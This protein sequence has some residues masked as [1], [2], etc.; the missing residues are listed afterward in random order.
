MKYQR[1]KTD[2]FRVIPVIPLEL[3]A[4][5]KSEYKQTIN[6]FTRMNQSGSGGKK[7]MVKGKEAYRDAP[8][9]SYKLHWKD[10]KIHQYATLP[11]SDTLRPQLQR[12]IHED[13]Q[14][15]KLIQEKLD[16]S[17]D[18]LHAFAVTG[19]PQ[20]YALDLDGE[21]QAKI[22]R[23]IRS[24]GKSQLLYS[25]T[26]KEVEDHDKKRQE[27][28]QRLDG[29]NPDNK[30]SVGINETKRMAA[31]VGKSFYDFWYRESPEVKE[32]HQNI[33]QAFGSVLPDKKRKFPMTKRKLA[34]T[35]RYMQVEIL[36]LIWT[37][38]GEVVKTFRQSLQS[39]FTEMQGENQLEVVAVTPDLARVQKGH[40]QYDVIPQLCLYQKELSK[41]LILPGI[42]E[43]DDSF[44]K[45]YESKT[46]IPKEMLVNEP[47]AIA[48]AR[49]LNTGQPIV[50]PRPT[51]VNALDDYSTPV[52]MPGQMGAGKSV[53]LINQVAETFC[54]D[55]K[56]QE[57]WKKRARSAIVFDPADGEMIS[58]ILS[59]IPDW[60]KDRVVVLNHFDTENPIP[61]T[62]HD[63]LKMSREYGNDGAEFE[64]AQTETQILLDSLEDSSSTR[65]IERFYQNALQASYALGSGTM[66]DA[67]RI[68]ID[69]DYRAEMIQNLQGV[70]DILRFNLKK[71]DMALKRDEKGIITDTIDNHLSEVQNNKP[72]MDAISQD[73]N[74][75]ID[76]WKWMNGDEDGAYLVLIYIPEKVGKQ[77]RKFLFTHYFL[78]IWKMMK[79]RE[80]IPKKQRKECLVIVDEIHQIIDQRGV[81][82]IF[83]DIFK[84]PRKYRVRYFFTFHGWSSLEKAGRSKK[85]IIQS[86][87]DSGCN[88]IMLKGGKDTFEDV[89]TMMEPYSVQ[90]F[91]SLMGMEFTAIFKVAHQKKSHVF[92]AKLIEPVETRYPVYQQVRLTQYKNDQYGRKKLEVRRKI[93]EELDRLFE[94]LQEKEEKRQEKKM[95]KGKK[96][97]IEE[98]PIL[99]F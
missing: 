2:C 46:E 50:Q 7:V 12:A 64:I 80:A 29:V 82:N 93:S 53:Q 55:A 4:E 8:N 52:I 69:E 81:K 74:E 35:N 16:L 95:G 59:V 75:K 21:Y 9:V 98:I 62:S 54:L 70:D 45:E 91:T 24:V 42:D 57:E 22:K 3:S 71:D 20:Q 38:D 15:I 61:V 96:N 41:F 31:R 87:K 25:L 11:K 63:L 73:E 39:L 13:G 44:Y 66:L 26:I 23:L 32:R 77:L 5:E 37:E 90:D 60:L 92:M 43:I 83:G 89:A 86:M 6:T 85:E 48:F 34:D 28:T 36:F 99:E 17:L 76:F 68:I 94:V 30:F 10:Q 79:L 19:L 84:E 47:G 33:M 18:N 51:N 1:I 14:S 67:M 27:L 49:D 65:S 58:S 78:K 72:W 56:S 88:L 40:L 97:K